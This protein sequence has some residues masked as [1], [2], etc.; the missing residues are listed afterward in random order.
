[1]EETRYSVSSRKMVSTLSH[2]LNLKPHKFLNRGGKNRTHC[3]TAYYC[4]DYGC[5]FHRHSVPTILLILL[6][7]Q[8]MAVQ[9]VFRMILATAAM[10]ASCL[11]FNKR[12]T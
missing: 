6:Y 3:L 11:L 10:P 9:T 8:F 12:Q 1:M 7:L 2:I 4:E 5:R